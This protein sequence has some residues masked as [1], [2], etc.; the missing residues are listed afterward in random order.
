MDQQSITK[1]SHPSM[2]TSMGE[3]VEIQYLFVVTQE[4]PNHE[5]GLADMV[6]AIVRHFQ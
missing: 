3:A 6:C 5:Q 4:L 2:C 1:E